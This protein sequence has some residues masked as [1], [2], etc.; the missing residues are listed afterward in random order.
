MENELAIITFDLAESQTRIITS[1]LNLLYNL[2]FATVS[3]YILN[4]KF[5]D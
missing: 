3:S 1:G 4:G 2:L 5:D